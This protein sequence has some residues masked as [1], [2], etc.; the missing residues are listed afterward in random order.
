VQG[1][2]R[3]RVRRTPPIIIARLNA[4]IVKILRSP[5]IKNRLSALG[6]ETVGGTPEQYA[7]H[8]KEELA[9]Y[10]R[11]MKAAGIKAD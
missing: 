11:I 5:D 2:T 7:A 9:K 1:Q 8:L 6:L 3:R 4:E 10:A